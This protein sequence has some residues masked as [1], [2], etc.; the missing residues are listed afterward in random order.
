MLTDGTDITAVLDIGDTSVVGDRRL[1]P[2]AAVVYLG[3]PEITPVDT[4]AD[5][6]VATSWLRAAGLDEWLAP[7]GSWL[8][9]FW[10]SAVDDPRVLGW[11]RRVL[12]PHR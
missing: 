10:S 12:L 9:A 3:S 8:A 2:V 1:D 4:S 11:C 7:A 5:L 6:D